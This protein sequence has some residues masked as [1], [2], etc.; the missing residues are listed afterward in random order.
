[1]KTNINAD[2][3]DKF[4]DSRDLT[5]RVASDGMLLNL[6]IFLNNEEDFVIPDESNDFSSFVEGIENHHVCLNAGL[7]IQTHLQWNLQ[8]FLNK[9]SLLP[10]SGLSF[11]K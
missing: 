9:F 8:I 11:I 10:N 5:T 3:T 7:T 1:M 4:W 2:L 6:K